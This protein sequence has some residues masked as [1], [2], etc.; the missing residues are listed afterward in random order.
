MK[1]VSP[2]PLVVGF[3]LLVTAGGCAAA[4]SGFSPSYA[5]TSPAAI[6]YAPVAA[7][8]AVKLYVADREDT[9]IYDRDAFQLD[10]DEL[11]AVDGVDGVHVGDVRSSDRPVEGAEA[12]AAL[13]CGWGP[14]YA[15]R[16]ESSADDTLLSERCSG[17]EPAR[18]RQAG[19]PLV[20]GLLADLRGKAAASGC[21]AVGEVRCFSQR[22]QGAPRA[23]CEGRCYRPDGS[24]R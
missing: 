24:A 19:S 12:Q 10:L 3:A 11:R 22:T 18:D 16:Y 2:S 1:T 23:W 9:P 21:A 8:D 4:S 15:H 6:H 13:W 7:A 14:P 17:R 20:S 5:T